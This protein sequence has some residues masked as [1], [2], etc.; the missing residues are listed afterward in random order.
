MKGDRERCLAAGMDGYLSKPI[1]GR[2]MIALVESL[3]ARS[4]SG[5]GGTI[6]SPDT[7][8]SAGGF[9]DPEW[10]RLRRMAEQQLRTGTTH[11]ALSASEA[12]AQAL[13]HEL[14]VHQIELDMQNEELLRAQAAAQEASKKYSDLFDFAPIGYFVWDAEGRILEANLAGAALLG[15]DRNAAIHKRFGQF[16]AAEYRPRFADFCQRVLLADDKQTC[17]VKILKDT[18]AVGVMIEGIAS[19]DHQGQERLCRAAVI[20]ISQRKN[21]PSKTAHL[22]ATDVFDPE[23]ALSRC[24]ESRE[25]LREMIQCFIEEVDSVFPQMRAALAKEDL[26]EVGRLG[27]RMKGTV[28]YLGAPRA[29]EAARG[30]E[31]FCKSSDGTPAEAEDAVNQLEREC[32]ALKAE[33]HARP[34][35]TDRT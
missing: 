14:Q 29:E 5:A 22:P 13:V 30:V 26:V 16:L 31:R 9:F 32:M 18:Q 3:A 25:M 1:D 23:L 8:S 28:V 17:E 35:V 12:D 24:F 11:R 4:H 19:Q 6:P 2:E 21:G 34:L 15:L 7:E 33:L 10:T 27:H 20:D